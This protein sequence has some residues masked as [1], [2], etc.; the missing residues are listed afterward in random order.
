MGLCYPLEFAEAEVCRFVKSKIDGFYEDSRNFLGRPSPGP[1]AASAR[2][3][4]VA[5]RSALVHGGRPALAAAVAVLGN[6][7]AF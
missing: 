3:S 2:S 1:P 7:F 6:I 4:Y 5:N